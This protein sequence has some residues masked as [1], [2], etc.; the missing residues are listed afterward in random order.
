MGLKC[1]W[2]EDTKSCKAL[3]DVHNYTG[4]SNCL[5][6]TEQIILRMKACQGLSDCASCTQTT[7]DCVW[8]D[9]VCSY[10]RNCT[11]KTANV[12]DSPAMCDKAEPKESQMT[13]PD[14]NCSEITSCGDCTETASCIWCQNQRLCVS[15]YG[16]PAVF[17]YGQ[18]RDSNIFKEQ[19]LDVNASTFEWCSVYK[20]CTECGNDLA[21]GWC[22]DLSGTGTGK[23]L[24]GSARGSFT[25]R[26]SDQWYFTECPSEFHII[27]TYD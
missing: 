14:E 18:C 23:C 26:S 11:D 5:E 12:I 17:P 13:F 25:C 10:R 1:L 9:G 21:C 20:N 16:Y 3:K 7:N 22:D 15:R 8:C 4:Y 24:H 2:I 6:H 27:C 19:C